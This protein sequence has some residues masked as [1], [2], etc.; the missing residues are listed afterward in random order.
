MPRLI[1]PAGRSPARLREET[2]DGA[3]L[4][5]RRRRGERADVRGLRRQLP[6]PLGVAVGDG[7]RHVGGKP[8]ERTPPERH[9][10]QIA[11]R[12]P[13]TGEHVV[14]REDEPVG[15][16]DQ[17]R[18]PVRRDQPAGKE[19]LPVLDRVDLAERR[20]GV[21]GHEVQVGM[22]VDQPGDLVGRQLS[23][24]DHD[25]RRSRIA[26]DQR[27]SS[28]PGRPWFAASGRS[29][30]A[31]VGRRPRCS[32]ADAGG[33][34]TAA[35]GT[36]RRGPS[37]RARAPRRPPRPSGC[38]HRRS[39]ARRAPGRPPRPSS[40]A[41]ATPRAAHAA[42]SPAA[43]ASRRAMRFIPRAGRSPSIAPAPPAP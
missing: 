11:V 31:R 21:R 22:G 27:R 20:V 30:W 24:V 33:G 32:R 25:N 9:L 8:A 28:R 40:C 5:A 26:G 42:A 3:Q 23:H 6:Q 10:R 37:G 43:A 4:V 17:Q 29:A 41:R 19:G 35:C 16:G 12:D 38:A 15:V 2:G 14:V 7:L 18:P 13:V 1:P 36:R 34:S 39:R